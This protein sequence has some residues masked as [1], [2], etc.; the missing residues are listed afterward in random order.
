MGNEE[1][2][3]TALHP[4]RKRQ[5]YQSFLDEFIREVE[6]LSVYSERCWEKLCEEV[7]IYLP[8]ESKFSWKVT[9]MEKEEIPEH[10]IHLQCAYLVR[11]GL[12]ER[13][14]VGGYWPF[15]MGDRGILTGEEQ[16]AGEFADC[17]GNK[18]LIASL[19]ILALLKSGHRNRERGIEFSVC[20]CGV[21]QIY[22]PDRMFDSVV[23]YEKNPGRIVSRA[24]SKH[25][26]ENKIWHNWHHACTSLLPLVGDLQRSKK[27]FED[28]YYLA[29]YLAQEF[30]LLS[31]KYS[32]CTYNFVS[33][34]D[35]IVMS[36]IE[37][38][39]K[40]YKKGRKE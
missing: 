18:H 24:A 27:I 3:A 9:W 16:T 19:F 28:Y 38:I 32:V 20:E 31:S 4:A 11:E 33:E 37:D 22:Y 25:L 34:P 36:R 2:L 12:Y 26:E 29:A 17:N 8:G 35:P 40:R 6:S 10:K 23:F 5:N 21:N 15:P 14:D 39:A 30:V 13:G 1:A 7:N